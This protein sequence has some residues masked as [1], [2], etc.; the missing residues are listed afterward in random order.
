MAQCKKGAVQAIVFPFAIHFDG[1]A[2]ALFGFAIGKCACA[3]IIGL[4]IARG[5]TH[6]DAFAGV[7]GGSQ[8]QANM[9]VAILV[10]GTGFAHT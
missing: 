6:F 5:C 2:I 1:V 4:F 3:D 7:F 10:G 8:I 9:T